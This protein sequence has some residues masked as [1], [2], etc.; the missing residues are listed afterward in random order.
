MSLTAI[1]P[2]AD[3]ALTLF[4]ARKTRNS[5]E[6]VVPVQ[7]LYASVARARTSVPR[8]F[9]P[10]HT[11]SGVP[12]PAPLHRVVP[13]Q[14]LVEAGGFAWA[15]APPSWL[16]SL[17]DGME[18]PSRALLALFEDGHRL[19]PPHAPHDAIRAKGLGRYSHWGDGLWLSTSDYSNPNINGR[20]YEAWIPVL[21]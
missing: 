4:A 20:R 21:E 18:N 10:Y 3:T 19:G 11:E 15:A 6:E 7:S 8:L 16:A 13:L 12:N 17:G 2:G 14:A 9:P 5:A 1:S